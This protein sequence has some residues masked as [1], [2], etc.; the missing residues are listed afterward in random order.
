MTS[1]KSNSLEV[2]WR[3]SFAFCRT[4][5]Y[6]DWSMKKV[7]LY[8]HQDVAVSAV[9][10]TTYLVNWLESQTSA[11]RPRTGATSKVPGRHIS[12]ISPTYPSLI[13]TYFYRFSHI[14]PPQ[15][16]P[17]L[18][19]PCLYPHPVPNFASN[20]DREVCYRYWQP[21]HSA[22]RRALVCYA[23]GSGKWCVCLQ[24]KRDRCGMGSRCYAVLD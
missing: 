21:R 14:L 9:R 7:R 12:I 15:H 8:I 1:Q 16:P 13:L 23:T 22:N 10:S 20:V 2:I 17:R 19:V 11:A 18:T 24:D 6:V 3:L 5:S 4:N